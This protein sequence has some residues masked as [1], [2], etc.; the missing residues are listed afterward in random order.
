MA[1]SFFTSG[2]KPQ[3]LI[4]MIGSILLV[5][6]VSAE[7]LINNS[8]ECRAAKRSIE[9]DTAINA[10]VGRV[11]EFGFYATSKTDNDDLHSWISLSVKGAKKN[12][13]VKVF[14][15]KNERDEWIIERNE[16]IN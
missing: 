6:F 4:S 14:F 7:I 16:I 9:S 2:I 12:I 15:R 3:V 10:L 13:R 1:A 5:L 8:N 11:E